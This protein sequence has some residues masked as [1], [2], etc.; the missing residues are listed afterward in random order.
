VRLFADAYP[1]EVSGVVL[2]ESMNP[3]TAARSETA[4][5]TGWLSIATIPARIGVPRLLAGPL[6]MQAGLAPEL[7]SAYIAHSV[8]PRSVQTSLDEFVGVSQGLAEASQVTSLGAVPLIVLSRGPDQD[9]DW[10][11]KQTELVGLSS[12]SEHLFAEQSGHNVHIDQPA[13]A[14]HAILQM[15]EHVRAQRS[16]QDS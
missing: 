11:R 10:Q 5:P 16:S 3:G 15:V 13:A 2:I 7:A 1:A 12:D 8:T 6:D 4:A 9:L 14:V